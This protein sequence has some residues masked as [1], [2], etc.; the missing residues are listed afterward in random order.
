MKTLE[1]IR[2]ALPQYPVEV[3]FPDID[4]WRF[5]NTGVDFVHTFDS[6][7]DGPHVMILALMHGNEVSG[8]IAVDRLLKQGLHPIKGRVTLGFG[9]VTA[10]ARFNP[11]DADASRYIDEDMNRVWTAARLDG[12]ED[13]SELRRAR[14]L[15]PVIDTVDFMLDLHS[16]HEAAPPLIVSGPLDKGMEFAARLGTPQHVVVDKG[17]PNGVRMRDYAG[18]GDPASAKNALLVECGQHFSAASERVAQ[19]VAAR[20]LLAAGVVEEADVA[21]LLQPG[22]LPAQRFIGVTEPVVAQGMAL[23][24]ADDYRGMEV[25]AKAGTV[26]ANENGRA[27]TTPYDDCTLVMPSLRHIGPGVTVVRLGRSIAR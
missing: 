9:N 3:Q 2:A 16:M 15:R 27:I 17:H 5:G 8:A 6:H 25:I 24:F 4:R 1:Q 23:E 11:Q 12:D 7:I 19:D 20:F 26:I 21:A 13:S 18:F 22:E 10:Y 14:E